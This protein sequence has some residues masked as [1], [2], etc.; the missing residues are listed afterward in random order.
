MRR[1]LIALALTLATASCGG[2]LVSEQAAGGRGATG[3][4]DAGGSGGAGGRGG[5]GG[6]AGSLG[7]GGTSGSFGVGG[8]SGSGGSFG[9][10]GSTGAGGSGGTGAC[11][12]GG[13]CA[14]DGATCTGPGCCP[15]S[16]Q[17]RGGSWQFSVCPSCPAPHCPEI[18][19]NPGE[20]CDA[21]FVPQEGCT[22]D[23]CP[24]PQ[25]FATCSDRQWQVKVEPCGGCCTGDAQCGELKVCVTS[26]CKDVTS[27]GC[28]RDDQCTLGSFCSGVYVCPC[29]A[30]CTRTD[31]P[32]TCVPDGAGCCHTD[33]DCNSGE[34]CERGVCKIPPAVG[35]CWSDRDC[36]GGFCWNPVI[37]PCGALCK[38][39]DALGQ[40]GYI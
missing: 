29:L 31:T 18:A 36:L 10:A 23:G 38:R 32:G 13:T 12:L 16:L 3:G 17:C 14:A 9:T 15:C 2:K 35:S 1:T 5:T 25:L 6:A 4:S 33:D 27:G 22:Y 34:H 24:E 26:V 7:R 21:C 30:D 8:S 11:V 37:C 39:P 40:C 28:W 20:A 19:P